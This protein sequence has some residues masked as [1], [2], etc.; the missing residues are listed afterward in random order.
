MC[1]K[2]NREAFLIATRNGWKVSVEKRE[3][4]SKQSQVQVE[5]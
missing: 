4:S 5:P 2:C 1:P 3:K